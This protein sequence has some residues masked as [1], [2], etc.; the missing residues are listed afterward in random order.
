MFVRNVSAVLI[1]YKETMPQQFDIRLDALGANAA[2]IPKRAV[3]LTSGV[4]GDNTFYLETFGC[5]MNV[6]DSEKVAGVLM[7]RG[8]QQVETIDAARLVLYNT[9]S[10]REKAAQKI[11]S[12]LGAYRRISRAKRKLSAC[13]AAS[14]QQEGR[15]ASPEAPPLGAPGVRLGELQQA[16]GVDQRSSK[17]AN[18]RV[19]HGLDK[20]TESDVCS[21]S[22]TRQSDSRV[23]RS[24]HRGLRQGLLLLRRANCHARLPRAGAQPRERVGARRERAAWP[25]RAA[26]EI[27]LLGQTVNSYNDPSPKRMTFAE[28]LMAVAA[29]A[30]E[31]SAACASPHNH[32]R[33]IFKARHRR[34][35][36]RHAEAACSHVHPPV[37]FRARRASCDTMQRTYTR[38]EYLE[39][40]AMIS[41]CAPASMTSD[42]IVGSPGETEADLEESTLLAGCRP[43]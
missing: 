24:D 28:L 11:Y 35:H 42:I 39:K 20:D 22:L 43:V 5:Q 1:I 18:R 21:K 38:D 14:A 2:D 30:R 7:G 37:Q 19:A 29:Y 9:C 31:E 34:G 16:T 12:R 15:R 17:P 4:P 23:S 25:T 13:W 32:H 40:I 26:Q 6:H 3:A 41:R 10:I 33:A 27:Q 8:Y 36:R